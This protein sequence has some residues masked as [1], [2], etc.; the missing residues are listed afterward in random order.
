MLASSGVEPLVFTEVS[1]AAGL[2]ATMRCGGAEKRW[3]PE[4]NGSGV[5]WIDYDGDGLQDLLIVN[6]GTMSQLA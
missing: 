1:D 2:H 4:A 3:I 5:A 6:G